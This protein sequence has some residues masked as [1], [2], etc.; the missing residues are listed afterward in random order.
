[1]NSVV[2]IFHHEQS[3]SRSSPQA[4]LENGVCMC[5]KIMHNTKWRE[6][7]DCYVE[8][9]NWENNGEEEENLL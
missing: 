7:H 5:D 8:T 1:L 4:I 9:L 2:E 3:D 6:I